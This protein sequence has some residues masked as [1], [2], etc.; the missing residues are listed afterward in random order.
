MQFDR[1]ADVP[2]TD[3]RKARLDVADTVGRQPEGE[4][5]IA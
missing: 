5:G 3:V 1:G 2:G 4:A